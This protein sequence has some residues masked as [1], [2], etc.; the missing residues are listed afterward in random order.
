MVCFFLFFPF[1]TIVHNSDDDDND[2]DNE[3]NGDDDDAA[4]DQSTMT[5]AIMALSW[6]SSCALVRKMDSNNEI[7][8]RRLKERT[9]G[10][11]GGG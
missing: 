7:Q 6:P 10:A 1:C 2:D 4:D 3:D 8:P 5:M 11:E 9:V